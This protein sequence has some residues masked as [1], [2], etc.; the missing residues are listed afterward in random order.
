MAKIGNKRDPI[1]QAPL[2]EPG[3]SLRENIESRFYETTVPWL[4]IA[5]LGVTFAAVEWFRWATAAAYQPFAITI[6]AI[7]IVGIAGW[8]IAQVRRL[9]PQWQLGLK[10]ERAIGQFLQSELLPRNYYV[11]HDICVNDANVDHAVIGPCGVFAIEVKTHSKPERG[12]TRISYDGKRILVNGFPPDRDP[13]IQ[14]RAEAKSIQQILEDYTGRKVA[15][16]P[17]VLYPGWFV[18]EPA[19]VDVWVLNETRFLGYLNQEPVK[20]TDEQVREIANGL[21]RYVRDQLKS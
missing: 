18:E 4:A 12:Q 16:R 15:V 3:Q 1:S 10:G 21:M 6:V 19:G 8:K 17:V 20:F 7:V 13:L 2:R 9:L 11:I 14:A 5:V